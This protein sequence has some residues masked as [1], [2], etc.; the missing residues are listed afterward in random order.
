MMAQIRIAPF[1]CVSVCRTAIWFRLCGIGFSVDLDMPVLFSERHGFRK[2]RR[3]GRW[4]FEVL[5]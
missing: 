4:S 3:W 2:V 5:R 1:F